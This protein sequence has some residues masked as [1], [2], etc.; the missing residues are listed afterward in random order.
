MCIG[1]QEKNKKEKSAIEPNHDITLDT[2][3]SSNRYR[4]TTNY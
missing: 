1:N 3:R 4:G 2:R